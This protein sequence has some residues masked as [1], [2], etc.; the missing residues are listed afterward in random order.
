MTL[1][2]MLL[3][4]PSVC[5]RPV[6]NIDDNCAGNDGEID[7]FRSP[8]P[9]SSNFNTIMSHAHIV[10]V[11]AKSN[12]TNRLHSITTLLDLGCG[13]G[14]MITWFKTNFKNL[15]IGDGVDFSKYKIDIARK[16][17]SILGLDGI[18]FYCIDIR[19]VLNPSF[20][21]PYFYDL[22][23]VSE[24]LEHFKDPFDSVIVHAKNLLS[25]NG[26]IVGL[27]ALHSPWVDRMQVFHDVDD[28][29]RKLHPYFVDVDSHHVYLLWTKNS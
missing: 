3:C 28:I 1:I 11:F 4:K 10:N 24:V 12:A 6:L 19:R 22:I 2:I 23:I 21:T 27:I 29:K 7:V 25:A 20:K 8:S 9:Q 14:R 26:F 5:L 17:S 15:E 18:R 16:R 13:D